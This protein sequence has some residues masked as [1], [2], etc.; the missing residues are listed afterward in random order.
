MNINIQ[1]IFK[2][3]EEFGL[4][5]INKCEDASLPFQFYKNVNNRMAIFIVWKP[6]WDQLEITETTNLEDYYFR[7]G[8]SHLSLRNDNTFSISEEDLRSA[9]KSFCDSLDKN[10]KELKEKEIKYKLRKLE[11]DFK[12]D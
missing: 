12:N 1:Q 11:G 8:I 9:Y 3:C 6:Y 5:T 7:D 10:I 2:L 4:E